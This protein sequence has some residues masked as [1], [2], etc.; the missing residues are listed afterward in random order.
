MSKSVILTAEVKMI[1]ILCDAVAFCF[2]PIS[3]LNTTIKYLKSQCQEKNLE[4]KVTL[5]ACDSSLELAD[6]NVYDTILQ[7]DTESQEEL[8]KFES[9]FKKSHFFI[10]DTNPISAKYASQFSNLILVYIDILFWMWPEVP[11]FLKNS[12][13]YFI[14]NFNG[15]DKNIQR[16]GQDIK[17]PIIVGPILDE[18]F[19]KQGENNRENKLLVSFGGIESALTRSGINTNYP[20]LITDILLTSLESNNPFDNVV[21]TGGKKAINKLSQKYSFQNIHF[22][23]MPHEAFLKELSKV[24]KAAISPGLTTAYEVFAYQVPAMFLPSQN[25]SQYLQLEKFRRLQ[26]A[27]HSFDWIDVMST[28]IREYEAE[29]IA[30]R[31]VLECINKFEKDPA[32]HEKLTH[33]LIGFFQ[34]NTAEFKTHL[35][36][37]AQYLHSLGSSGALKIARVLSEQIVQLC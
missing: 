7:C 33:A 21:I 37:Q 22:Y 12:D 28:G 26:L 18:S 14:E 5:L 3:T 17:N 6:P 4:I 1:E 34:E 30:V 25:Y 13:F 24:C 8:S 23:M 15:V 2:G 16:I 19:K 31:K 32:M 29:E 10:N 11:I 9:L 20:D 36:S 35:D 27:P